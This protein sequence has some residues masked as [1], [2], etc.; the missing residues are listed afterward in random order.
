MQNH[1]LPEIKLLTVSYLINKIT[2]EFKHCCLHNRMQRCPSSWWNL[3]PKIAGKV[4]YLLRP[5]DSNGRTPALCFKKKISAWMHLITNT[6]TNYLQSVP[7]PSDRGLLF[8]NCNSKEKPVIVL[9][10]VSSS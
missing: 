10:L 2:R 1:Y 6:V 4:P 9:S 7:F 5:G 8:Y 3:Y